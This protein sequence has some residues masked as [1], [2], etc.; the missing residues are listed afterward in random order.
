MLSGGFP[1][2]YTT[3]GNDYVAG[4]SGSRL[5]LCAPL[6]LP[7]APISQRLLVPGVVTDITERSVGVVLQLG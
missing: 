2:S 7:T 1:L 5:A 6:G 4:L 3:E